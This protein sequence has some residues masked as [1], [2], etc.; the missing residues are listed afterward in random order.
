M[1]PIAILGAA[2]RMGQMLIRCAQRTPAVRVVAALEV[3][4]H[5]SIGQDAGLLAGAGSIGVPI[6]SGGT[7]QAAVAIDFT[8]HA[9]VVANLAAARSS[10]QGVVLG[11]TGLTDAEQQAVRDASAEIPIVWAAN[12]SLGVNVL[13][14]L[15]RRAAAILGPEYDAELIEMHHRHKKDSPSGT[16]LAL[17]EALARGRGVA[18]RDVACY[19]RE[20]MVGERPRGQIGIHA[21]RGGDVVGDHT[22]V[23]AAE[24]E[25]VEIVHRAGNRE[26]FALGA[27]RAA[28]WVHGRQ[29]G[30]Y[31][32]RD[33]LGLQ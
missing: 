28:T 22:I 19:G 31:T 10:K 27:L 24:G 14:D 15:V 25:R 4:G 1:T 5:P 18:L 13:L 23:F 9:A 7:A 20:G 17:A 3:G 26:C 8:S 12:M 30:L 33:V 32:M 21:V 16:A 29:P 6:A 11:T 2:G